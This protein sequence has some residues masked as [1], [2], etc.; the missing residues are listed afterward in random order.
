[1]LAL[2]EEAVMLADSPMPVTL[3]HAAYR[4]MRAVLDEMGIDQV[5]G[6]LLD[7]GLSSD[8]LAWEGRGF[9]F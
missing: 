1:M 2:A 4:E 7:L 3:V 6:V 9:S 5:Q 8:Q